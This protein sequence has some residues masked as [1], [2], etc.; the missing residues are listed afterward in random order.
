MAI[1]HKLG[2]LLGSTCGALLVIAC[3]ATGSSVDNGAVGAGG[4]SG[5]GPS[6]FSARNSAELFAWDHVP[7]FEAT[8]PAERW[9]YL[10]EHAR[11]ELYE[12]AELRFEG[13][14]L[15]TVGLR[16][17]GNVGTLFS[18]FDAQGHLI[19]SKLSMKL[20]FDEYRP[21]ARFFGLKRLNLHAMAHDGSRLHERLGYDLFR[22]VGVLAPRSAWAVLKINGESQ[23]LFSMVEQVDGRFTADRFPKNGDGNLYKEAWP[24]HGEAAYYQAHLETEPA[25]DTA[26]RHVTVSALGAELAETAEPA[27]KRAALEQRMDLGYLARYMAVDDAIAN[28]D[29]VTALYAGATPSAY[30]NHNFYLYLE[31][32]QPKLWLIPWDL[33]ATFTPRGDF[34]IIPR[35]NGP[36]PECSRSYLVWGSAYV[37]P[38]ACDP[39][40]QALAA[41][42]SAY[43]TAVD[44]LLA[45]PFSEAALSSKIEQHAAFIEQAV[46]EDATGPGTSAWHA[47]VAALKDRLR[48]L[49]ARL[50]S[51]R[52]GQS[53]VPFT[54]SLTGANDFET[55]DAGSVAFGAAPLSNSRSSVQAAL[56]DSS[57]LAGARDLRLDFVYRNEGEPPNNPWGQWI[58]LPLRLESAPRDLSRLSGV[59]L[60]LR[61]DSPRTLRIDLDSTEYEASVEGIKFGWEV[62]VGPQPSAVELRLSDAALPAWGH[63]TADQ[64]SRV[65]ARVEGL[66]FQPYCA[67]RDLNGFLPAGASDP[68]FLE[69]DEIEFF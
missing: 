10:R 4:D 11:D 60:L 25:D 30:Q 65:L 14:A 37:V 5:A 43:R 23:G 62:Q 69:I 67:G 27:A 17:K 6:E 22:E 7:V 34:E 26:A 58:Y 24:V 50:T 21:D 51:A 38:P 46:A 66:A 8:L 53:V 44:E 57:A 9:S 33:D 52:E 36:T 54:L 15:G 13:K 28:V 56:Q 64:L 12:P 40:F 2:S 61:A 20:S 18:C 59:R 32:K 55:Q 1:Q 63:P 41:E 29:G 31:E 35:W 45:G 42:P 68:G 39:L 19:C 48:L 3:S 47:E 16:F 49:R